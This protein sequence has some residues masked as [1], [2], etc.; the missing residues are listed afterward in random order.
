MVGLQ[1][2]LHRAWH[3]QRVFRFAVSVKHLRLHRVAQAATVSE[4]G[5]ILV[6]ITESSQPLKWKAMDWAGGV[7]F[8]VEAL[9]L[10]LL[11]SPSPPPSGSVKT[12][13]K[14][15]WRFIRVLPTRSSMC[16]ALPHVRK[17]MESCVSQSKGSQERLLYEGVSKSSR[18][19][20]ITK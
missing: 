7:W 11:Q 1:T 15:S 6:N 12:T 18:T 5:F 3:S 4:V 10:L 19:E 17:L 20:S 9:L 2:R 8:L 14:R 13:R 16:W